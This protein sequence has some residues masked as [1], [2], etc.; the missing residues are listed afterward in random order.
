ME[1]PLPGQAHRSLRL[2]LLSALIGL[3]VLLCGAAATA[4]VLL[5]SSKPAEG[6]VE[7]LK[8]N[9][10]PERPLVTVFEEFRRGG[11]R[12]SYG[13][14]SSSH[15]GEYVVI[16]PERVI[17]KTVITPDSAGLVVSIT[18]EIWSA[19][20]TPP[21]VR[22]LIDDSVVTSLPDSS[23]SVPVEEPWD[24]A[25]WLDAQLTL[26]MHLESRGYTYTGRSSLNGHPSIRYERRTPVS[27]SVLE[28]VEANPLL[29]RESRYSISDDGT[30][31]LEYQTTVT[32]V[33]AGEPTAASDAGTGQG[34]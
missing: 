13:N 32:S 6:A 2:P 15:L 8:K 11:H 25:G 1:Q 19:D 33:S 5:S 27:L 10:S 14:H 17:S 24:L 23:P 18:A 22:S 30:L 31:M 9:I 26:P 29:N 34:G 7:A 4:V 12:T 3:L 28:F 16:Y 21:V 20:G